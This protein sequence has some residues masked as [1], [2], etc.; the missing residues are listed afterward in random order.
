ML[1]RASALA[2]WHRE[3]HRLLDRCLETLGDSARAEKCR[4]QRRELEASDAQVGRVLLRY[5]QAP[6]DAALRFEIAQ[7]A[8]RNGREADGIRWLFGTLLVDPRHGPT[9]A[10]LADYL[11]RTGQPRRSAEHRRLQ[12][13]LSGHA[14]SP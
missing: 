8:L 5:R 14:Q 4:A 10:A 13:S 12:F 6:K 11:E 2:P 7:W 9:H 1:S 3:A